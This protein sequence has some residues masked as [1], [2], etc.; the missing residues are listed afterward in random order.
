MYF[1]NTYQSLTCLILFLH[2]FLKYFALVPSA[3]DCC[4]LGRERGEKQRT[5]A[6]VSGTQASSDYI[7][8]GREVGGLILC[9]YVYA[10]ITLA[11][12]LACQT[13]KV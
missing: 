10:K 11:V 8:L 3:A 7:I 13:K 4:L 9:M 5:V 12:R 1:W 2:F 6:R